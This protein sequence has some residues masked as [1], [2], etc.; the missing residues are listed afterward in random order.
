MQVQIPSTWHALLSALC[1]K[2]IKN[3]KPRPQASL[4]DI[5][6]VGMWYHPETKKS[7]FFILA[8]DEGSRLRVGQLIGE[9]KHQSVSGQDFINFFAR[10]PLEPLF[11]N[12]EVV[13]LDPAQ[14]AG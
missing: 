13:R 7:W 11:G 12:P 4:E 5:P 2:R 1:V 6:H 8:V 14:H 3:P 9:G 10:E